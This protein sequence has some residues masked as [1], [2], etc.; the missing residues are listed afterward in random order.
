M[1]RWLGTQ[2]WLDPRPGGLYRVEL[3]PNHIQRGQYV[4]VTPYTRIVFTW[5]WEGENTLVP[6][7]SSTVKITLVPDGSDTILYLE[8]SGLPLSGHSTAE[9]WDRNLEKLVRVA[10]GISEQGFEV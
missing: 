2:C 9:G 7:G 6:P 1:V 5:G 3:N 4:E 8:H 10:E